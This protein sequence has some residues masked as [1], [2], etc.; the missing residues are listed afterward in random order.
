MKWSHLPVLKNTSIS[1]IIEVISKAKHN[2]LTWEV[3]KGHP[4]IFLTLFEKLL[5]VSE[6]VSEKLRKAANNKKKTSSA[7]PTWDDMY[8][9][10][11]YP[12][13]HEAPK[14]IENFSH[15]LEKTLSNSL[16]IALSLDETCKLEMCLRGMI[17]SQSFALWALVTS[18]SSCT[19]LIA[20]LIIL[21]LDIWSPVWPWPLM[22]RWRSPF[23]W[24][25]FYNTSATK[26]MF[27]IFQYRHTH[28]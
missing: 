6:E 25:P 7:L 4:C 5:A 17:E 19:M 11:D 23:W 9:L 13:F 14:L 26:L 2:C 8:H 12:E 16:S 3:P 20:S 28:L 15:L 18:F 10:S 1:N 24:Q 21:C 27:H 22:H